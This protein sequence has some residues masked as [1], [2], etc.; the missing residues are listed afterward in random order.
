MLPPTDAERDGLKRKLSEQ[1]KEALDNVTN[2]TD[3][4]KIDAAVKQATDAAKTA[5]DLAT[6]AFRKAREPG[7]T[8]HDEDVDVELDDFARELQKA[9]QDL[10]TAGDKKKAFNWP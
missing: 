8:S 5:L 1:L 7:H 9:A 6:A 10:K 2:A 3:K 4:A